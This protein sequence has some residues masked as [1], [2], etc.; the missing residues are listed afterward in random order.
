CRRR[1]CSRSGRRSGRC[2]GTTRRQSREDHDSRKGTRANG[3][4]SAFHK[5][6]KESR[7]AESA[8]LD[9]FSPGH[10]RLL[11]VRLAKPRSN[12]RSGERIEPTAQP[13]AR[14]GAQESPEGGK[15]RH[16]EAIATM[17]LLTDSARSPALLHRPAKSRRSQNLLPPMQETQQLQPIPAIPQSDSSACASLLLARAAFLLATSRSTEF[18]SIPARWHSRKFHAWPIPPPETSSA[19]RPPTCLRCRPPLQE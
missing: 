6:R 3:S 18:G 12:P 7:I 10:S 4:V 17:A 19:T 11:A 1:L 16:T 5:K 13:A 9:R 2:C 8:V 14:I 15:K